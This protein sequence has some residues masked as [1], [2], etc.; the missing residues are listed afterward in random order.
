VATLRVLKELLVNMKKHSQARI[1]S[2]VFRRDEKHLHMRYTDDGIGMGA[3]KANRGSGL[4][5]AESRIHAI[6]GTFIFDRSKE[7]GSK[8]DIQIP[9]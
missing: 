4:A 3:N 1:V 2:I 8:L 9:L 6:G 7:K 5:N